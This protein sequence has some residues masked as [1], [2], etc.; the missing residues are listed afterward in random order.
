MGQINLRKEPDGWRATIERQGHV[1]VID[2]F[3]EDEIDAAFAAIE[4][5]KN[6]RL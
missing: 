5:E 2:G 4:T 6:A 1:V 3:F